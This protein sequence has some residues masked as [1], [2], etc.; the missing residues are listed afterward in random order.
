MDA[1]RLPARLNLRLASLVS[2]LSSADAAPPRQAHLVYEHLAEAAHRELGR[3]QT[4]VE[5]DV[6]E[7][8]TLV[9]EASLP[10]IATR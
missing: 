8:N 1:L 2:V 6:A 10:A 5:S 9:R 4:L 3:L 7:F